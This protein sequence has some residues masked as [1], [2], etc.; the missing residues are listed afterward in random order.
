MPVPSTLFHY[1]TIL[2][3]Q[4]LQAF[5]QWTKPN[6]TS[7]AHGALSD[8]TRSKSELILE[9]ALLRQQLIVLERQVKR[10][11]L[12]WRERGVMVFLSGWLK[13]W[14]ETVLIVQP[15]TILRWHRDLFRLVW[16]RKSRSEA[17]HGRPPM[18]AEKI[19]LIQRLARENHLWG[20]ERIRGELL[21]LGVRVARSTV[22]KYVQRLRITGP[23]DQSWATFLRN[24]APQIWACAL[25]QTYDILFRTIFV[26]VIIELGSRRVVH[27][28]VTRHPTDAWIAQQLREATPF[29]ARPDY[30]IHDND[31]KFGLKV[32]AAAAGTEIEVL[33]TP[34]E[35][36]KAN[37]ICERF[38]GSLRHEC[39]DH[40]LILRERH[41]YRVVKEYVAFF[42]HARPHQGI[43]QQIPCAPSSLEE[44]L[45]LGGANISHP[46]LGGLHHDYRRAA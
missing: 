32:A 26:F 45:P 31:G 34:V 29:R 12:T 36:P 8:F 17:R 6:R 5:R 20:A 41:L 7:L 10:P 3:T 19:N 16:R 33:H 18:A 4:L 15:D 1:L 27:F 44:D 28:N 22:Q 23:G 40:I 11:Q 14:K 39:L 21:K 46:V 24:H 35:A 9:N 37:A 13:T 42:N 38:I 2:G 25:V 43:H 30:L